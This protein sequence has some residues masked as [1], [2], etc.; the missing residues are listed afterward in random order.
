MEQLLDQLHAGARRQFPLQRLA[1]ITR[2]LLAL[3]FVP[4][5]LVK[6][7]GLPFTVM[8]PETT[9]GYFFDAMHRTGAYWR[10]IGW[11]QLLTGVLLLIPRT[12]TLGA[13]MFL[14]IIANIFVITVSLHF[15]G[16]PVITGGMLLAAVF[17]LCWD[18]HRLK[19]IV[20]WTAAPRIALAPAVPVGRLELAGYGLGTIGG[21]IVLAITRSLVPGSLMLPGLVLGAAGAVVVLTAWVRMHRRRAVSA[22]IAA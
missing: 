16:T 4:T 2:I 18:Y 8:P 20:G 7:Q 3:A 6:V 13:V 11:C 9:V 5:A 10:F 21:M 1:I 14:P 19:G 12:A 15:Q 17:L 22:P